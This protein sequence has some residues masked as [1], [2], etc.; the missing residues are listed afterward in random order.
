MPLRTKKHLELFLTHIPI[1]LPLPS[2]S[3]R[4]LSSRPIRKILLCLRCR[5]LILLDF[6]SLFPYRV[7]MIVPRVSG[8]QAAIGHQL[9]IHGVAFY[10]ML[11]QVILVLPGRHL[12]QSLNLDVHWLLALPE[13]SLDQLSSQTSPILRQGHV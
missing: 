12:T 13:P 7:S 6:R 2:P 4:S 3:A 11:M 9:C 8:F 5:Y 1:S 10:H